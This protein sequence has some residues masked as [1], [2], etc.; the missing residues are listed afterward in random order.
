MYNLN[1]ML[2]HLH[3]TAHSWDMGLK[4]CVTEESMNKRGIIIRSYMNARL[5]CYTDA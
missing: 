3:L 5:N 1:C 2:V 4:L